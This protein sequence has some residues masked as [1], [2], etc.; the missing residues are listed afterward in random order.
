MENF[1]AIGRWRDKGKGGAIESGGVMPDGESFSGPV[2]LI[3]ILKKRQDKF[4]ELVTRKMLT[5]AL[6]RGLEIPDSC[7]VEDVVTDLEKNDFRF[8]RLIRGIVH[9]RSFLMRRGESGG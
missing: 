3:S 2:E 8:T 5:Y 7:T 6:G 4:V 9:S 1:D